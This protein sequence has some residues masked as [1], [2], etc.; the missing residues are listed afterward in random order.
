[1]HKRVRDVLD[2]APSASAPYISTE[3]RVGSFK[4]LNDPQAGQRNAE[5]RVLSYRFFLYP[6][7]PAAHP[8]RFSNLGGPEA[9]SEAAEAHADL[10]TTSGLARAVAQMLGGNGCAARLCS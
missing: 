2:D 10:G 4:I 6:H 1:M 7:L 3:L 5:S 9:L 8:A